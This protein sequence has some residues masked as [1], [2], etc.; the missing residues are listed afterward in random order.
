VN[1]LDTAPSYYDSDAA[2]RGLE[3][4]PEPH[5]VSIKPSARWTEGER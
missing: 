3:G 2:L 5:I 4:V 1:Y